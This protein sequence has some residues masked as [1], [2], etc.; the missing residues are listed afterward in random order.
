M[1]RRPL[2]P[3]VHGDV[4]DGYAALGEQLPRHPG[5]DIPVGQAITQIP[6]NRDR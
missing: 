4:V 2:H 6:P 1:A 5:L 3:P